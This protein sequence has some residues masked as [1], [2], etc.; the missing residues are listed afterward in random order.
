MSKFDRKFD[1]RQLRNAFGTFLTGVTVVTCREESGI[2]R[3]F[4]ANSFTSVS[5]RPPMLLICVDKTAESFDVFTQ[6]EGFAVNILAETQVETSGLFASKCADK[7]DI[8][9]WS[10]SENGNPIL[11]GVCAWFDCKRD[12]VIDAGDH[13]ILIGRVESYDY[14]GNMGLGYVRGGYLS[15]GLEQSALEAVSGD[16]EVIVGAI[17]EY[18]GKVLLIENAVT[19]ELQVPASGLDGASGS[20]GKL[21]NCLAQLGIGISLSVLFA[22]FENEKTGQQ[23]IYYRAKADSDLAGNKFWSFDEIPWQR[24]ESDAIKIMLQRYID[25]SKRQR[26]GIY[27]GSDRDG[28]IETLR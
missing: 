8:A 16:A 24:I 18:D 17:V 2:P 26:Y 14:N 19:G 13:I 15:L 5:L 11:E 10:E 22:V 12:Q 4:T 21:Q 25:E 1:L 7:F 3:G 9:D 28:A 6:S 23:S 27:F 20:L